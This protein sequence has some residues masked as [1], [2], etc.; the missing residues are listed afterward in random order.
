VCA[1]QNIGVALIV[2]QSTLTA[3]LAICIAVNAISAVIKE[4][5][6]VK[7]R[8]EQ[9]KLRDGDLTALDARN[10]LLSGAYSND[11]KGH[12]S[13]APV[14]DQFYT[15]EGMQQQPTIPMH[16]MEPAG[17]Y[18]QRNFSEHSG[19][20]LVGAA[21]PMSM[22]ENEYGE[23]PPTRNNDHMAAKAI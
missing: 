3:V 4:N 20:G 14:G 11:G 9:E 6:Y 10:S 22:V 13:Q 7:K 15:N 1:N 17:I 18:H 23:F 21:A 5:P 12:Y 2:I 16:S 19:R 8:K